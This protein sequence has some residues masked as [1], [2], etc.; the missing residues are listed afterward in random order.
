[1][2]LKVGYGHLNFFKKKY[3]F[4]N[5]SCQ[6]TDIFW[7]S[8]PSSSDVNN[9]LA[10]LIFDWEL[11][12]CFQILG[13]LFKHEIIQKLIKIKPVNI[14]VR[15][16][17]EFKSPSLLEELLSVDGFRNRVSCVLFKS[18]SPSKFS[19]PNVWLPILTVQTE[20]LLLGCLK[21][22]LSK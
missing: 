22:K 16:R 18:M 9:M 21:I 15:M 8:L 10:S 14:E 13:I 20:Q 4:F 3:V 11:G 2:T 12:C 5:W 6:G 1:M 17:E 19:M 7:S